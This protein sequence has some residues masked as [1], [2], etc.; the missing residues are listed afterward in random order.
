MIIEK[1]LLGEVQIHRVTA[2]W[3]ALLP[4]GDLYP[5]AD[6]YPRRTRSEFI[7]TA[8]TVTIRRGG[9]RNALGVKTDVGLMTFTLADD[10]DPLVDGTFQPGQTIQALAGGQPLFTGTVVDVGA[11]YPLNKATGVLRSRTTVTVAD[12]V[13]RHASTPR[14]GAMIGEPYYETFEARINRLAGSA[15]APVDPPVEGAPREVYAL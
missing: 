13:Q 10:E 7:S 9:I 1:P 12:A 2:L 11:A 15:L 3:T 6:L 8:T 4:A 5:A 14:Y